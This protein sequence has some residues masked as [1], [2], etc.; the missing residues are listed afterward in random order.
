MSRLHYDKATLS[1]GQCAQL[2]CLLEVA[3]RKPGN[4]HREVDFDDL[5]YID[6]VLSAVAIGPVLDRATELGVGHTVLE[7]VRRTRQLV[8]TNTNLGTVL[9]LAPLAAV[10]LEQRL[11]P[12]ITELL[13]KLT[14]ADAHLVYE[15]IR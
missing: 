5:H 8:R 15:A 2:A 9:L 10:P 1:A 6:F 14:L 12:A 3:A 4:V 13:E 7:C 11:R